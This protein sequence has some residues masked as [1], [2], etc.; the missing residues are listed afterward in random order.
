MECPSLP[1]DD[2]FNVYKPMLNT[3]EEDGTLLH[4]IIETVRQEREEGQQ[5]C[6]IMA[7][8]GLLIPVITPAGLK[9]DP[10]NTAAQPSSDENRRQEPAVVARPGESDSKPQTI[11]LT[12]E[13]KLFGAIPSKVE[14]YRDV[15][16]LQLW[17]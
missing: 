2:K 10:F 3:L 8:N 14:I 15:S 6:D 12:G 1:S 7:E 16:A 11:V 17:T 5:K 13:L 4:M 9:Q